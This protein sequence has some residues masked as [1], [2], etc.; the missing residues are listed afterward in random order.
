[1]DTP[2]SKNTKKPTVIPAKTRKYKVAEKAKAKK[3]LEKAE[4]K[5]EQTLKSKQPKKEKKKT[6]GRKLPTKAEIIERATEMHLEDQ[7][8]QGLPTITPEESE[9]KESG[10]FKEAQNELMRGI[11]SIVDPQVEKYIHELKDELEPHG[12]NIVPMGG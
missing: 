1:V 7:A 8:R 3:E 6:E 9:L 2:P 5:E 4:K 12:Y 10:L 11:D